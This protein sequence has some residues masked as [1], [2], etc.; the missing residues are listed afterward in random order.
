MKC[1]DALWVCWGG[2]SYSLSLD[3]LYGI[4]R[5]TIIPAPRLYGTILRVTNFTYDRRVLEPSA[6]VNRSLMHWTASR[7]ALTTSDNC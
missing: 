5:S 6:V 3:E 1:G 7:H 2:L 4:G